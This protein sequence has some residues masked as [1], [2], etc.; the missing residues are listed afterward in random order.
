MAYTKHSIFTALA[1]LLI[2]ISAAQQPNVKKENAVRESLLYGFRHPPEAA[3]PWVLWYWMQASVSREGIT[4]DLEAMKAAGIGGANLV[5]IKGVADPPLYTPVVEQLSPLWWEMVRHAFREADRLGLKIAFHNCDGFA[6]SGGPW[7]TPE[8]SMQRVVWSETHLAGGTRFN[9]TLPRPQNIYRN[10]YRDI[11]VFAFPTPDGAEQ[12]SYITVPKV[13]SSKSA[14]DMQYLAVKNNKQTFRSEDSC[15]IRYQF[16]QP[17]TCRSLTI[18]TD[19]HNYF[20][21]RMRIEVSDDGEQ[22]RPIGQ[23]EPPRHGWQDG[24]A[25]VT[26]ALPA[27]TARFFRFTW[28]KAG[29]EPGA[30]DLDAAKWKPALALRGIELSGEPKLHQYEGKN[31]SI[32]RISPR[33]TPQQVPDNLCVPMNKIINLTAQ[34]DKEGGLNW[35]PPAGRWTVVRIGHTS[36]GQTNYIGGKGL[37]LECDK[38]NPAAITLQFNS[39]FGEAVKQAGPELLKRVLKVFYIDSWECGSQNWSARFREEFKKRRGYDLMPYMLAMTGVP[40]E[41][42]DQ[43]ERFLYDV[44]ETIAEL[45]ND[46]FYKTMAALAHAKGATFVAEC[47]APTMVSDGMLHFGTVDVPM[48]EFWLRSPT[49]DKPND[50]LDAISGAHIYGKRIIQAES[51]TELHMSW[52]EHPGLLKALGDRNFALGINRFAFHVFSQNPWTDRR[53]GMTLGRTGLF[54]QRDQTWFRPGREWIS[55]IQRCQALLQKG[56]PVADVAVFTG[57]G[58]PR[59]AILPDRLVPV[60]PG[61]F[62]PQRVATEQKRL[63]NAGEPLIEQPKTIFSSANAPFPQDWEN[64]PLH[65]Y[66]Y[67]SYNRDALLRLSKVRNGRIELPGGASYGVLVVPGAYRGA[68][69]GNLMSVEVESRIEA[70]V[71]AGAKVRLGGKPEGTPGLQNWRE[72]G[73]E[74]MQGEPGLWHPHDQLAVVRS[75]VNPVVPYGKGSILTGSA[76]MIQN[77]NSLSIPPDFLV[78]NDQ[79]EDAGKVAWTHRT[80]PGF[81][82]YFISNQLDSARVLNLSLRVAGRRPEIWDPLTGETETAHDW[83]VEGGRTLLPVHMERNGSVFVIFT[84]AVQTKSSSG[85]KN[86]PQWTSVQTLQGPWQVHFDPKLGGPEKAVRFDQFTDWSKHP[87]TAIR[88][89]SGT[90]VYTKTFAAPAAS[91]TAPIWLDLGE[92]ANIAEVFING[93][94][95]GIAWTA[96]YRVNISKALKPGDN[97]LEI[98]VTNTWANRFTGDQRLP[99]P[100]RIVQTTAPYTLEG[101]PL[102]QA[103]LLGEVKIVREE[104]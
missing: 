36:T 104:W 42:A 16:D 12:S 99:E 51:F 77:F 88:Y 67:D 53:P 75:T 10:Y 34:L 26:H 11:A 83:K 52:D 87:D 66:A 6:T 70:L 3:K 68:P 84:A 72:R 63:A 62:G 41:S 59:R 93:Q 91:G 92:V 23:L 56:R 78:T 102:L 97:K 5:T 71:K 96:P 39:W 55:Y 31:G 2:L 38:F 61:F 7:I 103:G 20:S 90:A 28:S 76:E 95:C 64:D 49:H 29:S 21:N 69:D 89:Y 46:K 73:S 74:V 13:T 60:L 98:C 58:S 50:M 4:A 54:Y 32:W 25:D 24:D 27:V 100:R 43:S 47:V 9:D 85:G 94:S 40:V 80:G 57:E 17:F 82:L 19:G 33:T 8:L 65:G 22:Y 101:R 15:W 86:W 44:R 37:G 30:E 81:D 35:T 79:K 48:G 18:R 45:V 1:L 14:A